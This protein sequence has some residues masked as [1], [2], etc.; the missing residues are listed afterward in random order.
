[1][2][3]KGYKQTKEHKEKHKLKMFGKHWKIQDT[4]KYKK[5]KSKKHKLNIGI[6]KLGNKNPNYRGDDIKYGAKHKRIRVLKGNAKK[7]KCV[8]CGNPAVHWSNVDH[9]YSLN[10]D[11]YKARCQRCHRIYDV[12]LSNN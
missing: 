10:P 7:Y 11:D 8:D 9:E 3:H 4:S 5:P 6:A 12:N 2:P 1:M